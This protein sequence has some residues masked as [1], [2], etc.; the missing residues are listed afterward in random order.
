MG[1]REEKKAT[2]EAK[3]VEVD[4]RVIKRK[5]RGRWRR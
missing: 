3:E 1:G 2:T 5:M 4:K